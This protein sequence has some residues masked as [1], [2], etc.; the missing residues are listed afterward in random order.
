MCS[1]LPDRPS[2]EERESRTL[3]KPQLALELVRMALGSGNRALHAV[4]D[5]AYFGRSFLLALKQLGLIAYTR[6]R[7]NNTFWIDGVK[8]TAIE[9]ARAM[10][11]WKLYQNTAIRYSS[12]VA[13]WPGLGG[14]RLV[15]VQYLPTG[16]KTT[17]HAVLVCTDPSIS[18]RHII[19]IYLARWSI[20]VEVRNAKTECG[21]ENVYVRSYTSIV[22]YMV[23]CLL[24]VCLLRL[25]EKLVPSIGIAIPQIVEHFRLALQGS[26]Y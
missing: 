4:F 21:L 19:R 18:A 3:T 2:D 23:R 14:V 15:R 24:G 11:S 17:Q 10:K 9:W 26:L 7:A 22:N 16:E 20:E 25:M 12:T 6:A 5:S 8:R 13:E 1:E